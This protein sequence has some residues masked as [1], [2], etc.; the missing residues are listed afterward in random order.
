MTFYNSAKRTSSN[1][2][3][4]SISHVLNINRKRY[5]QSIHHYITC[6]IV[7]NVLFQVKGWSES[8]AVSN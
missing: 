1:I 3:L 8:G 5:R 4:S 6:R 7:V 2:M